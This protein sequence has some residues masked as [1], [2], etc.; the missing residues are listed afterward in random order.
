MY[1]NM[2]LSSISVSGL[3]PRK[4]LAATQKFSAPAPA[5]IAA[6]RGRSASRLLLQAAG[7]G[8]AV[9]I[10]ALLGTGTS[11]A[12]WNGR[13]VTNASTVTAGSTVIAI[14]GSSNYVIP[15]LTSVKLGPGRST[16]APFIITNTGNTPVSA[17]VA[18]TASTA[19]ALT[20][21]L[22]I[23]VTASGT[24]SAGLA[25]GTIGR[26]ATFST[27]PTPVLLR[28]GSSSTVCLEI[29]VDLDAPVSTANLASDFT[30]TVTA[31]QVRSA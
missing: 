13:A 15:T 25:G 27:T 10:F 22:S 18:T 31:T 30:L 14:N 21:E 12:L 29:V 5:Q 24:C 17:I 9:V 3:R 6:P 8:L 4:A 23:R 26:M 11:Y 7:A 16:F 20:D 19:N 2:R 28:A 1:L